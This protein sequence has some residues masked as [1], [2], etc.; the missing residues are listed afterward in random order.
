MGEEGER[1]KKEQL[2]GA[3]APGTEITPLIL[4]EPSLFGPWELEGVAVSS[5][6]LVGAGTPDTEIMPLILPNPA[7]FGLLGAGRVVRMLPCALTSRLP[8]L[9][10]IHSLAQS[11]WLCPPTL[12]VHPPELDEEEAGQ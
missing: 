2:L 8:C 3:G 7:F 1:R 6:R 12:C 9:S 10:P 5:A 11:T 4:L